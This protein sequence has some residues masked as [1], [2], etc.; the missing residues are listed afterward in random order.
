MAILQPSGLVGKVEAI[1]VNHGPDSER[2]ATEQDHVRVSYAGFEGDIYASLT[3]PAC[4][5]TKAQY[6]IGN[7]IRNVRQL[8]IIS[9]EELMEIG[10]TMG[11]PESVR[12]S[13]V[14]A[15]LVVSGFP[16]FTQIPPASRL[17]V[18]DGAAL[19]VDMENEACAVPGRLIEEFHPGFGK[20]FRKAAL[21]KRG[22]TAWVEREG[23]IRVGA[24]ITLHIPPQRLYEPVLNAS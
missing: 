19:A 5:R 22:V 15:N 17:L 16:Q 6:P 23:E 1:L 12:P 9:A 18:H 7:S 3:R 2:N 8:T 20:H 11:L 4:V 13:W 21:G 24:E 14:R 10:A